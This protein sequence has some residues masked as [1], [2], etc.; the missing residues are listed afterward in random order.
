TTQPYGYIFAG[1]EQPAIHYRGALLLLVDDAF[2]TTCSTEISTLIK[3]LSGDGWEVIRKDFPR[4]A[5]VATVKSYIVS[6][7]QS[8]S[9]L[10]AVYIL[11]HIA[12]P[13]SGDLN[14]DAHPDHKGAWPADVYY[15]D[16]NGTWTD[17]SVNNIT[18]ANQLNRNTPGDGKFDNS[19]IPSDIELQVGRVDFYDMP[20]FG[21]TEEQ[22]VKSYLNKAHQYKTGA[23]AVTKRALVDDNFKN[24]PEGFAGN[25]WRNFA[26][27]VGY[28]NVDEKDFISTLNT[29]FHQW[30]Y[31]CGAGS[32]TSCGGIGN[33]TNI[34]ANDMKAIFTPV[35][36][37]YF[38][39]W[40][41]K[42]NFLRAPLCAD[43]PSLASFWAGRPNWFLHHMALGEPIGYATRLSQNNN[44]TFYATPIPSLARTVSTALMGDPSLRTEYVK[45]V[46][47]ITLGGDSTKGAVVSWTAS[48]EAGVAGYYVYRATSEFG[49]YKLRSGMVTGTSYTDSFGAPGTYWYMVRATKLQTTPSG[50]YYN[51]SLGTSASGT[52]QYPYF[53]VGVPAVT[54]VAEVQL[55]P[56][57]AKE[58]VQLEITAAQSVPANIVIT[59]LQGKVMIAT[60]MQLAI[61]RNVQQVNI[62]TLPAG[63]YM[64]NV[65][66]GNSRKVLKLAHTY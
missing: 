24:M 45:P 19:Y 41:Y 63:M 50:T 31:G 16:L 37:S 65:Q 3:D 52:F 26:P 17:A 43:E 57:P 14:P 25:G 18:S 7:S 30:A 46:P 47:S 5:T 6:T 34:A 10:A 62:S 15:G 64:V 28:D 35:F 13:Y 53:D 61:G 2:T 40:N 20:A 44:G 36:G 9:K 59:D 11:G 1:I 55:Y 48:P 66:A 23:L 22:M 54:S 29:Q 12:V 33:T 21:K 8:N 58:S 56:N 38:G 27:L 49:E 60:T 51:M 42:N 4:T 32:Y 39:D